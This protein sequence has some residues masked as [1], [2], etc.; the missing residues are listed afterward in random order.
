[1]LAQ[2]PAG[3]VYELSLISQDGTRPSGIIEDIGPKV[4]TGKNR[5]TK[6]GIVLTQ[7][8]LGVSGFAVDDLIINL[9]N[10]AS[11][12]F[13]Y[14]L[15]SVKNPI[16]ASNKGGGLVFFLFDATQ[17]NLTIGANRAALGYAP[18]ANVS[19]QLKKGL[20]GGYLGIG[21]SS[22]V[23]RSPAV[24]RG[25]YGTGVMKTYELR[26]GIL[27]SE[28]A[29]KK[30]QPGISNNGD[31]V[32]NKGHITMRAGTM[33]SPYHDRGTPVLF[34][35]YFGGELIPDGYLSMAVLDGKKGDYDFS[36]FANDK[37]INI[38]DGGTEGALNFQRIKI[39]VSP[40][41]DQDGSSLVGT[42]ISISIIQ[43]GTIVPLVENFIYNDEFLVRNIYNQDTY[44]FK[45][46]VPE[47]VKFGFTAATGDFL[48]QIAVVR[49]LKVTS[50]DFLV[51]P[52]SSWEM[53]VKKSDNADNNNIG[54]I[55]S[56]I[57]FEDSDLD[58]NKQSFS[59]LNANGEK[60]G[61]TYDQSDV[62]TWKYDPST[63]EVSFTITGKYVTSSQ[64]MRAQYV[65]DN[66]S[67][68]TSQETVL[69]IS[70][71]EC[72]AKIN[73]QIESKAIKK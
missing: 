42:T 52:P 48:E 36:Y 50:L 29:A 37:L 65:I 12:E 1:M 69:T 55:S 38:L 20:Q 4:P 59:F 26:E 30:G 45:H 10:K 24:G 13:D 51:V 2:D 25:F 31:F 72:G 16:N 17:P 35:K 63:S 8:N 66:N 58:L 21:F 49:N 18:N 70:T 46:P 23:D 40:I 15:A 47:K 68:K 7:E 43:N 41:F 67:G 39:D 5:Y 19:G 34:T 22:Y 33:M 53:C 28:F 57:L 27:E 56:A 61:Q 64:N 6:D 11:F 60:V 71:I 54:G 44:T 14:A 3:G 32:Y 73:P 9:K 62:G